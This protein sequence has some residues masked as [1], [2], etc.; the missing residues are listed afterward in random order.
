MCKKEKK[1]NQELAY[2]ALGGCQIE[3]EKEEVKGSVYSGRLISRAGPLSIT[4]NDGA[5][6][7]RCTKLPL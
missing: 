3:T 1:L 7:D 4:V 6:N 5:V 2:A